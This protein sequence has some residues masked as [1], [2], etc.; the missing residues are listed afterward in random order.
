MKERVHTNKEYYGAHNVISMEC[1]KIT[2]TSNDALL[3]VNCGDR[4]CRRNALKKNQQI[5]IA[6]R[7]S[8]SRPRGGMRVKLVG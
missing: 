2:P 4:K 3:C 8:I 6:T 1:F 7:F 5:T